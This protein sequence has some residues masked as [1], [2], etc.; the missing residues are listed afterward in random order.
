MNKKRNKGDLIIIILWI[1]AGVVVLVQPEVTKVHYFCIW[2]VYVFHLVSDYLLGDYYY[3]KGFRDG[4][5]GAIDRC[6]K[7]IEEV[8]DKKKEDLKDGQIND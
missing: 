7:V 4:A 1:V 8:C 3:I 5:L 6:T 2:F